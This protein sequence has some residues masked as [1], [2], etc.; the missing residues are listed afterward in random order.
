MPVSDEND[1]SIAVR[2]YTQDVL[3]SAVLGG[4]QHLPELATPRHVPL[5]AT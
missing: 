2:G 1:M 5:I 4:L 3:R